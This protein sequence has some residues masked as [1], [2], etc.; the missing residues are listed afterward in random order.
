MAPLSS[1]DI[2]CEQIRREFGFVGVEVPGGDGF[3]VVN[4]SAKIEVT[5]VYTSRSSSRNGLGTSLDVERIF[6]NRIVHEREPEPEDG[7]DLTVMIT[8]PTTVDCPTGPGSCSSTVNFAIWN[9]GNQS[10]GSDFNRPG[11]SKG[12]NRYR[13]DSRGRWYRVAVG[14]ERTS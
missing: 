7:P 8:E 11:R 13:S 12:R 4:A 9:N 5:A 10:T 6:P 14:P 2:P 1:F 3:V